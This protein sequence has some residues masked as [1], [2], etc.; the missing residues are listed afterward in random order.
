MGNVHAKHSFPPQKFRSKYFMNLMII[1]VAIRLLMQ[2]TIT[3]FYTTISMY[4][5]YIPL[6]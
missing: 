5:I 1:L 2:L 3:S 4:I 6:T